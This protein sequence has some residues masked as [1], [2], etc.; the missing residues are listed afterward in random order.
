MQ[1]IDFEQITSQ[2]DL[3]LGI[4]PC[5]PTIDKCLM[6]CINILSPSKPIYDKSAFDRFKKANYLN[7]DPHSHGEYEPITESI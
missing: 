1:T 4:I 2:L 6:R 5:H 3:I 7:F